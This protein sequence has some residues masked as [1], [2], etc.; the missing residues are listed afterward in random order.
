MLEDDTDDCEVVFDGSAYYP[1]LTTLAQSSNAIRKLSTM[2]DLSF[3]AGRE[4]DA[5]LDWYGDA[6]DAVPEIF[7]T[8]QA[9][10]KA[11]AVLTAAFHAGQI[12]R[13]GSAPDRAFAVA[14]AHATIYADGVDFPEDASASAIELAVGRVAYKVAERHPVTGAEA[15]WC[16][17][18]GFDEVGLRPGRM[19]A[20]WSLERAAAGREEREANE[21]AAGERATLQA[22]ATASVLALVFGG[23]A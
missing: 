22:A 6:L 2:A 19:A 18:K 4:G 13:V 14:R 7:S 8:K 11:V 17:L 3:I 16:A 10:E 21:R 1:V 15:A 23:E 5:E 9:V 20:T 12:A